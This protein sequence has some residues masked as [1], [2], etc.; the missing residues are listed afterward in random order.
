[1]PLPDLFLDRLAEIVPSDRYED[2]V[3]SFE[4]PG[5]TGFRICTL[6]AEPEAVL[7]RLE[8]EGVQIE[9]VEGVPGAY[10]VP[11]EGRA[12]LMASGPYADGHIYLQN[13]S[14]Q[15]PPH[16][17]GIRSGER[18]LDLCAAPGSKTGQ[19]AAMLNGDGE[20]VAVEKVRERFYKLKA[21]IYAQGATNV[22]PWLGSGTAYWHREPESFDRV[23]LD[24]P[25][26]TEGR[27]RTH[28]PETTRYWS[29]RKI[30]E[31]RS[32]QQKLLFGGIQA[33]KPGGTLIYSTCTFAPEENEGVLA[34]ALRTFGDKI[35]LVDVTLPSSGRL[36][37][38]TTEGVTEWNGHTLDPQLKKARRVLP[39]GL[40]EGFFVA[41][42][43]KRASTVNG[44]A[45][46]GR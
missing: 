14:S 28:E 3:A 40:L 22:I 27:F 31:M 13:I 46:N 1:M 23:L 34:K 15:L 7:E 30:R 20:I 39:D 43:V 24:A 36:A 11:A 9:S 18:V 10:A 17:L 19:L 45:K 2:V 33:L 4:S 35:E 42:L 26:S 12:P 8:D 41:K 21:N 38:Q 29:A 6:L 25:C 32:K 5:G 44:H 16:L 37:A